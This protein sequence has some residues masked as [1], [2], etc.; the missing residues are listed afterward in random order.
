M[1]SDRFKFLLLNIG[2]F[3][4]HLLMLVFATAAALALSREW[5]LA[6]GELLAY[7]TPGFAAFGLFALTA[8][9]L[10]DRW[11]R[12]GMMIIF[13]VGAGFAAIATGFAR[14]PFEIGLGL[15]AVGVFA[16]IYHP[17]GLALVYEMAP[18][19]GM[20]IAINGVWG[21]LG[22]GSAALLTG[23]LI[24]VAGW[25]SAFFVPGVASIA[26][27][28]LYALAARSS[29]AQPRVSPGPSVPDAPEVRAII[30]RIAAITFFTTAIS[31]LVFQATTFALP[32]VFDERLRDIAG[33]ASQIGWL[34]FFVFGVASLA[35]LVVGALLD[36][37]GPKPVFIT[38]T[39]IQVL[40]FAS[41]PGME[42]W[43]A[44]VVALGFMVGAFGQIPIN[45]YIIGRLASGGRRA[46]VY[47]AR[48][49]VTFTALAAALPF[50][51]WV[52]ANWGFDMLF[53]VLAVAALLVLAA[54]TRL[55]SQLP[56]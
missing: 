53:R 3:L 7:A 19:A 55:P 40:F 32:K 2:H 20:A 10:A 24:D 21:N 27:G 54:A 35:Q 28:V 18:R 44:W 23:L 9:W 33:S 6:Y 43:A 48:F 34:A 29:P 11:S 47:G 49:V 37:V 30:L 41:M 13:F 26:L 50:I 1:T 8:G 5:G 25:R 14:S 36:R 17:V 4:D 12:D 56:R 38:V 22:V 16:A 52:H 46:S 39:A 45:D 42:G 51:A 15:F 31:G